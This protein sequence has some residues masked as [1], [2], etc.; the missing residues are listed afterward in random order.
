MKLKTSLHLFIVVSSLSIGLVACKKDTTKTTTTTADTDTSAASEDNLVDASFSD[1]HNIVDQAANGA[2]VTF[3]PALPTESTSSSSV[4]SFEKSSC[5]TITHDSISLPKT[6]KIDFGSTNCLCQDGK[7]RRGVI[8]VSYTGH[9]KDSAS[10]HTITFDNYFV[11][12]NQILG[13]KTVTN[14]G[15]KDGFLTYSIVVDGQV[16]K[17]NNGGTHTWKSTR[18]RKWLEGSTTP[19]WTDD[20]YSITGSASGTRANGNTY[21]TT[22]TTALHRAMSCHWFD[23]GVIEVKPANKLVRTLNYGAGTCDNTATVTLNGKDYTITLN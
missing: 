4:V 10:V 16:V 7:N 23:S 22:I 1:V 17:S 18:E 6:I 11:N 20:V 19:T 12:D 14:L 5:A 8:N 9:Y 15:H 2:L 21:T 3:L 13:T